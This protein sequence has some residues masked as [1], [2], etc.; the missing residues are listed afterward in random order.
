MS[1]SESVYVLTRCPL[2]KYFGAPQSSLSRCVL[3]KQAAQQE[4]LNLI[5]HDMTSNQLAAVKECENES[6]SEASSRNARVRIITETNRQDVVKILSPSFKAKPTIEEE[7]K[8]AKDI[9]QPN[10]TLTK[11]N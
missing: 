10:Q 3:S 5:A 11:S 1:H 6:G 9:V 4:I 8:V 7:Q 2:S